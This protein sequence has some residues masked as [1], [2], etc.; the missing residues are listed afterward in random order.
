MKDELTNFIVKY[1]YIVYD[2]FILFQISIHYNIK[3]LNVLNF[4]FTLKIII[5][6][7]KK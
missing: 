6:F 2:F 4:F 5:Y 1:F 3:F 7:E